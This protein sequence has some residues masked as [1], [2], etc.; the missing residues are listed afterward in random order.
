MAGTAFGNALEFMTRLGVFDVVLPFLLVFTLVFA[1]L[2]KTRVFGTEE[3]RAEKDGKH[4]SIPRKNLNS[5]VA[6]TMAF[7]VVAST[8][9]V[10]LINVVISQVVLVLILLFSFMLTMGSMH[11]QTKEGFFL[12]G[13]WLII[14]EIVA[15]LSIVIIFMNA[16][17]WLDIVLDWL[18]GA[19]TSETSMALI[20]VLVLVGI[21]VW[22]TWTPK[23]SSGSSEDSS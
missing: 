15:V 18:S 3:Y 20:M 13:V 12:K 11:K 14:F 7:F 2:E 16:L 9:L 6:F 5:M 19:F 23:P 1:F 22:V 17:G 10:A 4:Y 8:Q 21:I